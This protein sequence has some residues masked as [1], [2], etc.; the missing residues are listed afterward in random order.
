MTTAAPAGAGDPPYGLAASCRPSCR[1]PA[2]EGIVERAGR[3]P[4]SAEDDPA[5]DLVPVDH[6]RSVVVA[7]SR[8]PD[9]IGRT[10]HIAADCGGAAW[11]API[12]ARRF[13]TG[14]ALLSTVRSG[15]GPRPADDR[16]IAPL[17]VAPG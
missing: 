16:A 2:P 11:T 9:T 14:P 5:F 13:R 15:P 8:R 17:S 4:A 10:F 7:L 6:V 1:L 3:C 12:E